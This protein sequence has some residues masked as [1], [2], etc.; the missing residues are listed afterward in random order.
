[1]SVPEHHASRVFPFAAAAFVIGAGLVWRFV[2]LGLPIL[3][4]KYGGSLLW[5]AMVYF[6]VAFLRPDWRTW[7]IVAA[8]GVIAVV[9]EL[10]RLYHQ[11]WLDAFRMTL[12][13]ALSRE[14]SRARSSVV[15]IDRWPRPTLTQPRSHAVPGHSRART[16][17]RREPAVVARIR[18]RFQNHALL[19]VNSK[20][21]DR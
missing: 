21:F 10:L 9:V 16:L 8:A 18:D 11:P 6:L 2:P 1:M 14:A 12:A 13:G 17:R 19:N 7:T 20:S 5:G 4:L 15:V 3:T